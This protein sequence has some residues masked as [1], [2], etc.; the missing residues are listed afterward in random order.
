MMIFPTW[1][2]YW[3]CLII[4][5]ILRKGR[6]HLRLSSPYGENLLALSYFNNLLRHY[7]KEAFKQ[8]ASTWYCDMWH[9]ST[10]PSLLGGLDSSS[11]LHYLYPPFQTS[12]NIAYMSDC[13]THN[14]SPQSSAQRC[15]PRRH[16]HPTAALPS[17]AELLKSRHDRIM[18]PRRLMVYI[19][20]DNMAS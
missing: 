13:P 2:R 12:S 3:Q 6:R 19:K 4:C 17:R 15:S 7:C 16:Q 20:I 8:V 18:L 5:T 14:S 9:L 10:E 1:K 11:L